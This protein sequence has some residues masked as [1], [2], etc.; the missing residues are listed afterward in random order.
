VTK[1][2]EW[3]FNYSVLEVLER[4]KEHEDYH[5]QHLRYWEGEYE[6]LSTEMR[7]S[8]RVEEQEIT[9]GVNQVLRYDPGLEKKANEARNR[10]NTHEIQARA[11]GAWVFTLER[12]VGRVGQEA[13]GRTFL[14]LDFEDVNFF[15]S[16][17]K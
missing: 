11:F 16:E 14:D 13:A 5:R 2:D 6:K 1:R 10:K 9:G 3:L 7:E 17:P 8:A 15:F 4:A 12:T